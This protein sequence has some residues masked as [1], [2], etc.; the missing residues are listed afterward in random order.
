MW[1]AFTV[2]VLYSVDLGF[3]GILPRSF[4]GLIG[5]FTAPIIHGDLSHLISN[6][7]PVLFLGSTLFFFY[8]RIGG[9]VFVRCYF[10]TNLLVWLFSPRVSYHIGASGLVYGLSAFLIFFG[11]LRKD[12]ISLLIS[13]MITIFYGGIFYGVLPIDPRI[14]WESH[15]SGFLV[16]TVSAFNLARVK[17]VA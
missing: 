10:I 6:T 15:L 3:L 2:Q 14:S 5:V 7:L 12:F 16:G 13:I 8:P 11:L 1:A 4:F 17:R 9:L